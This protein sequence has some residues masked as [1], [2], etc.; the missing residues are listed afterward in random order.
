MSWWSKKTEQEVTLFDK[1]DHIVVPAPPEFGS[2]QWFVNLIQEDYHQVLSHLDEKV[3]ETFKKQRTTWTTED[4]KERE[5]LR[6]LLAAADSLPFETLPTHEKAKIYDLI[7]NEEH[8]RSLSSIVLRL[9][10]YGDGLFMDISETIDNDKLFKAISTELAGVK[11]RNFGKE[12]L[13][14][15]LEMEGSPNLPHKTTVYQ[16]VNDQLPNIAG[17]L[18]RIPMETLT[19]EDTYFVEQVKESYIPEIINAAHQARRF[20][21]GKYQEASR[22]FASQLELI[23][24]KLESISQE[25]SAKTL[26]MVKR[27]TDALSEILAQP[28]RK[29]LN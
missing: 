15:G 17:L 2:V 29:E 12:S 22:Y 11:T 7:V 8:V 20:E 23:I 26:D 9:R 4:A 6:S 13:L 18:N 19:V 27:Q 25:S 28:Q 24:A 21:G 14:A 10:A 1:S 16:V 5:T 3:V